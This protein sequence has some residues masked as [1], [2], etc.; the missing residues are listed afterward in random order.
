MG[1]HEDYH[2]LWEYH[3]ILVG[4]LEHLDYF[5]IYWEQS[6][7]LTKSYFSEGWRK[8]TT[9]HIQIRG[10]PLNHGCIATFDDRRVDHVT[11]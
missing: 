10:V 6:S 4:A 5:S 11:T 1:N 2:C 3:R 9:R 7:Q 8:T